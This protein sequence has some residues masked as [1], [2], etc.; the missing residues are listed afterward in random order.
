[1]LTLRQTTSAAL[2]RATL[3]TKTAVMADGLIQAVMRTTGI[4][5]AMT[6]VVVIVTTALATLVM[7][8]PPLLPVELTVMLARDERIGTRHAMIAEATTIEM[9]VGMVHTLLE[10]LE[11]PLLMIEPQ[12]PLLA[13][14]IITGTMVVETVTHTLGDRFPHIQRVLSTRTQHSLSPSSCHGNMFE[15]M[16]SHGVY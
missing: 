14:E 8:T 1:M 12:C 4:L 11:A 13:Q 9:A 6:T 10:V 5:L 7:N 3:H 16:R 15:V 2:L